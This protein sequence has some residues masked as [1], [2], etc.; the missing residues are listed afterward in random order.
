MPLTPVQVGDLKDAIGAYAFPPTYYDFVDGAPVHAANMTT[1]ETTIQSMLRSPDPTIV[2][3]GLANVLYWGYAQIGF[4]PTRVCRFW[5]RV[6]ENQIAQYQALIVA[7]GAPSPRQINEIGMP[8]YSGISFISKILMF[9]NPVNYCVL[10]LQL[11]QL[12]LV[13]GDRPIH[14]LVVHGT[15]IGPTRHNQ[16]IYNAWCAE[17]VAISHRYFGGI[18]RIPLYTSHPA[19]S[20]SRA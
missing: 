13:P 16:A 9:L 5:T 18:Y 17:C 3:Q 4:G 15:T 19:S 14:R 12:A 8:E 2:K 6:T 7:H 11:A 10:D 20:S 1:V